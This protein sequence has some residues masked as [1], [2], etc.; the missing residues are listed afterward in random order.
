MV[1][2]CYARRTRSDRNKW[3]AHCI[4]LDLWA[5]GKSIE[6]ARSSMEDAVRGYLTVVF[7]TKDRASIPRLLR[8]RAQ[9]RYFVLWYLIALWT[10]I[11]RDRHPPLDSESF[12]EAVPWGPAIA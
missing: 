3:I 4:D 7:D 2:R 1:F 9:L 10:F 12:E 6:D 5:A 8:R 11:S